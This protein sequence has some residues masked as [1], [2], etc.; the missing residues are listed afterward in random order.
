MTFAAVLWPRK[1]GLPA[2]VC[3][4]GD[5][6]GTWPPSPRC[7]GLP[8]RRDAVPLP[9]P[10][11]RRMGMSMTDVIYGQVHL[12]PPLVELG[13]LT[14]V[15]TRGVTLWNATF[16][17]LELMRINSRS[18]SGTTLSGIEPGAI[19][20]TGTARGRLTVLAAGPAQQDTAYTFVTGLGERRLTITAMRV[21][22][23]PFWPDWSGGLEMDYVF[24]TVIT[25]G[26]TGGE[27]R[28]PLAKRPLRTLRASVWGDGV[29]GQ[30]LHQLVQQGK[31]RVFGVP[32][33]QEARAVTDISATRLTL[34]LDRSFEAC[35]NLSRL[36]G[37]VMLHE[38]RSDSFMAASLADRNPAG[39]TLTLAAPVEERFAAGDCRVIPLFTG[40]LTRAEP[41]TLSDDMEI[42]TVAFQEMGGAQPAL[43]GLPHAPADFAEPWLWPHRPDWSGNGPGGTS[44]LVRIMRTVRG[45]VTEV[46]SKRASAPITHRQ[47][48]VLREAELARL[49]DGVTALR[50]RW[51]ALRVRDPRRAFT[52]TRESEADKAV[53]YA[54]D[55]GAKEAFTPGQR[56]WIVPKAG[57]SPLSRT[58]LGVE[59][60][61]A[62]EVALHLNA[63]LGV[64]VSPDAFVGREYQA[65]L[66]TD[67]VTVRYQTAGIARCEL[68]FCTLSEE[69]S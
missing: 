66:D 28:R 33:W 58:L 57:A 69:V 34:V 10:S 67:T 56:L 20:P 13:L 39:K 50:G 55:N 32:V 26:E 25:R 5:A 8:S 64:T 6:A 22:L 36:C 31:D 4:P 11:G 38:R 12:Y 59:S 62:G 47:G 49:L 63:E 2:S 9:R 43:E 45:G 29:R 7:G 21:L 35:W 3:L 48:Y 30:R 41:R 60:G 42:W 68:S 65:R 18:P 19:A 46:G 61:E 53:L 27:Q 40:V 24:D 37:L 16:A 44:A 15:E 1:T 17:P 14:G 51:R 54:R 23:F 52:L